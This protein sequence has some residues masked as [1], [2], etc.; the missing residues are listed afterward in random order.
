M[1]KNHKGGT[2]KSTNVLVEYENN[3]RMCRV[4]SSILAGEL[5][6]FP[7]I[8]ISPCGKFHT[9]HF[10]IQTLHWTFRSSLNMST[11]HDCTDL[12]P[13]DDLCYSYRLTGC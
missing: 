10:A 11:V 12:A 2:S 1:K 7:K 8:A 13:V 9:M 5:H 4:F 3:Q 6:L